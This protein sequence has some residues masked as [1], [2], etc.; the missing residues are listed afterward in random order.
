MLCW[1][2]PDINKNQPYTYIYPL[3]LETPSQLPLYHTLL[4]VTEHQAELPASYS[5]FPLAIYFTH[6]RAYMSMP[7][8]QFI[9]PSPSPAVLIS[10]FSIAALQIGASHFCLFFRD[11]FTWG[12]SSELSRK[13]KLNGLEFS[14]GNDSVNINAELFKLS[15]IDYRLNLLQST[16][17]LSKSLSF[18]KSRMW[19]TKLYSIIQLYFVKERMTEIMLDK[20]KTS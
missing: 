10:L 3:P 14:E 12:L 18:N 9:P 8:S 20:E 6:G 15:E 11:V 17:Q 1:F 4:G 16:K 2:L 5:K 19:N 7:L 13:I